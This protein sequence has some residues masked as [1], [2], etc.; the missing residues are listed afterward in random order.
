MKW[1]KY[2]DQYPRDIIADFTGVKPRTV[3][4]WK[5]RGIPAKQVAAVRALKKSVKIPGKRERVRTLKS[6]DEETL[7]ELSSLAGKEVDFATVKKWKIKGDI[8]PEFRG[9]LID[10][11][12]EPT[13]RDVSPRREIVRKEFRRW[14]FHEVSWEIEQPV[15]DSLVVELT[16]LVAG[17]KP[18]K[19]AKK[20]FLLE[21]DVTIAFADED[22]LKYATGKYYFTDT[23]TRVE[24]FTEQWRDYRKAIKS[25][26]R[27]MLDYVRKGFFLKKLTLL[28]SERKGVDRG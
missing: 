22:L 17:Q 8:P 10:A 25:L 14:I 28:I 2:L 20:Q 5:R 21:G 27:S 13:T 12:A 7:I 24:A 16:R 26:T 11:A 19:T 4:T 15:S 9:F 6:T 18:P 1:P 3:S 23:E